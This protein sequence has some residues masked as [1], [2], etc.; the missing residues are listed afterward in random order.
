[1]YHPYALSMEHLPDEHE[2]L[3]GLREGGDVDDTVECAHVL[4]EPKV[5]N[6]QSMKPKKQ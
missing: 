1:M 6:T 3:D 5:R 2:R 4:K